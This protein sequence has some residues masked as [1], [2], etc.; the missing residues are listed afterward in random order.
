MREIEVKAKIADKEAVKKQLENLGCV[1][2]EPVRQEDAIY[3]DPAIPF[4][5]FKPDINL[6]RIRKENGKIIFTLKRPQI[7]EQDALEHETEIKNA[8]EME[9]AIKL[10]GFEKMVEVR[11]TRQTAKYKNYTICL[12]EVEGLGSFVEVE[13]F[14]DDGDPEKIQEEIFKFLLSL[15]VK[16]EDRITQGYDT[17]AYLKNLK[18]AK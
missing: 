3:S 12:D 8:V 2:S 15:G 13:T 9:A 7:N 16:P 4:E 5:V 17:L 11:K 18:G 6:L 14:S 1:F 10:L